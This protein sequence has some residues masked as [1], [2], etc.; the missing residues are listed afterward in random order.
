MDGTSST[1]SHNDV[2]GRAFEPGARPIWH[3]D[4][5]QQSSAGRLQP[6]RHQKLLDYPKELLGIDRLLQVRGV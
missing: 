1:G 6:Q 2:S 4:V 5:K 3:G